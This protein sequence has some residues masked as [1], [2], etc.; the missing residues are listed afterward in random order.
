M[1][2]TNLLSENQA[3][4]MYS[5]EEVEPK[6]TLHSCLTNRTLEYFQNY[7]FLHPPINQ[8]SRNRYINIFQDKSK[9][10][11]LWKFVSSLV[12]KYNQRRRLKN[13]C[14]GEVLNFVID[15]MQKDVEFW[16]KHHKRKDGNNNLPL[17]KHL[18]DIDAESNSYNEE[19]V[20]LILSSLI[21]FIKVIFVDFFFWQAIL[22]D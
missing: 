4:T 20:E 11:T 12:E 21:S 18:F 19:N 1:M 2:A 5:D 8:L 9:S 15:V 13:K 6:R 3:T 16:C 7:L 17:V 14:N 10:V 22:Q